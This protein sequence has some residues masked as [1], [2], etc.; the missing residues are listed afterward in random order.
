MAYPSELTSQ[1]KAGDSI[2]QF[3]ELQYGW[4]AVTEERVI[5]SARVY[6]KDTKTKSNEVGN[7]PI[8][9]I[10]NI[11]TVQQKT[12]CFGKSAI[13]EINMQGAVYQLMVGKDISKVK[14][15]IQAFNERS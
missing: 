8:S 1:L 10:T 6:Y 5:Y 11:R 13:L 14:P 9:K 4:I 2:V 12:G 15:I 7:Y 3:A